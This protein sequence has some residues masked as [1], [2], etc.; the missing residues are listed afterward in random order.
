VLGHPNNEICLWIMVFPS[1]LMNNGGSL[2]ILISAGGGIVRTKDSSIFQVIT[3]RFWRSQHP[4]RKVLAEP[5]AK[6]LG[7]CITMV[8]DCRTV[9]MRAMVFLLGIDHKTINSFFD[10]HFIGG[11]T[12][13]L[14][15]MQPPSLHQLWIRSL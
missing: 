14:W 9:P 15:G 12:L 10:S 13:M 11:M 8:S 7:D 6:K 4:K 5:K 3:E 2:L 1:L